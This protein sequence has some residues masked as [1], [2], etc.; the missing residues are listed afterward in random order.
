MSLHI[1]L[2][3]LPDNSHRDDVV[4]MMPCSGLLPIHIEH[5]SEKGTSELH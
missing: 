2:V 3:L 4:P 5:A 1:Q